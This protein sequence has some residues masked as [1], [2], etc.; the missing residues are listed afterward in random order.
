[1]LYIH[2]TYVLCGMYV[3]GGEGDRVGVSH[4]GSLCV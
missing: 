2:M 1:V 3:R 4:I